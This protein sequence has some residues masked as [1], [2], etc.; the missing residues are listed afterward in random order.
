MIFPK[1]GG[2]VF[3]HL[4]TTRRTI[5]LPRTIYC[6]RI[7]PKEKSAQSRRRLMKRAL[8][9]GFWERKIVRQNRQKSRWYQKMAPCHQN[10]I[11]LRQR[12]ARCHPLNSRPKNLLG[13]QSRQKKKALLIRLARR[14]RQ[15]DV[16]SPARDQA[17][18]K[19][20]LEHCRDRK[21]FFRKLMNLASWLEVSLD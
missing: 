12:R 10:Q 5:L 4:P 7:K 15:H 16:K 6:S 19:T 8:R 18:R 9:K 14:L 2:L 20:F 17:W 3:N 1:A 13:L 11:F 21:K